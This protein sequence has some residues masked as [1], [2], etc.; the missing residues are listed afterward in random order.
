MSTAATVAGAPPVSP[1]QRVRQALAVAGVEWRRHLLGRRYVAVYLLPVLP[2]AVCTVR[3][4]LPLEFGDP[5]ATDLFFG[6]LFLALVLRVALFFAAFS[7]FSTLFRSEVLDRT[8]HYALLVPM[9]RGVLMAGKYVAAVVTTFGAFAV[10]TV[11]AAVMAY[12]PHGSAGYA[13]L[14]GGTGFLHL[15]IYL[16]MIF[17]ACAGYGALFLLVG[18]WVRN[19]IFPAALLFGWETI[20]FLL[21]PAL[22][23]LSVTWWLQA[24]SPVTPSDGPFA[25]VAE[26]PSVPVSIA[27]LI[28]QA[29]VF[30]GL[31]A[32]KLRRTEVV[33]GAE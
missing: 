23:T 17:L 20:N 27:V 15:L 9:R 5:A 11:L 2:V 8:L 6:N 28:V 33:Y 26:A 21:P 13:Y 14:F 24:L 4:F 12:L 7:V 25:V 19:M 31:A 1:A 10:G 22:K 18:L 30:L 32:W 29:A 16:A 3:R